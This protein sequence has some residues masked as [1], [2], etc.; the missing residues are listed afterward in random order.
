LFLKYILW[1]RDNEPVASFDF[2]GNGDIDLNDVV[3]LLQ[4]MV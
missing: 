4:D 1:I 2:N 3:L